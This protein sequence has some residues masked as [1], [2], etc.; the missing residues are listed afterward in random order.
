MFRILTGGAVTPLTLEALLAVLL[1]GSP[2][3]LF[4]SPL[5]AGPGWDRSGISLGQIPDPQPGNHSHA[6]QT[7]T[8]RDPTTGSRQVIE[9]GSAGFDH[10]K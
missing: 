1:V 2:F 7:Q 4:R 5:V 3:R 8:C 10:E 6:G 9:N